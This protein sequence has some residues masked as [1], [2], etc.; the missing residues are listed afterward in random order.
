MQRAAVISLHTSPLLQ[1][2]SGDSGGMNVY[3]RELVSALAQAGV[4]CTTFTRADR[5]GLPREVVVEPGH[6]VVHIEAGPHHLPKEAL[7]DITDQFR[8]G[9]LDWFARNE[10]PDVIHGNYW[11]S[12]VVGHS[13]KH[14]LDVPFVSTFHTLARVKAAGGDPESMQRD[15]AEAQI[16]RCADAICVSCIEEEDQFRLH[17]G[18]PEARVEIIA[19]GV[20]HAFFAPGDRAGARRALGFDVDRPLLLFVGRIQPLKG[21]DVAIRALHELGDPQA[22]LVIVGGASG[23]DGDTETRRAHALVDELGLHDRVRFVE[24]QPHHILSTYYRA[25]DVV[26]APSRSESFGSG[27]TRGGGVRDPRGR[28]RCRRPA[29][30]RRR[31]SHRSTHRR[32]RSQRLRPC[33]CRDPRGRHVARL[34]ERGGGRTGAALHVEFR[35]RPTAPSLRRPHRAGTGDLSVSE[36]YDSGELAELEHRID[37]WLATLAAENERIIAVDRDTDAIRWY[38][39]MRGD[40]KEFT[41]VWLTLGQRTLRYETYVMPAPEENDAELYEHLL[42]RNDRLVGAHFSIGIEDAIFLRGEMPVGQVTHDE[43][44]RV[45]GT[46]YADVEQC[47]QSLLRIGFRSRFTA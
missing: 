41:T 2:G 11:L 18:N 19:P 29:Q 23:L 38:V 24:P 20:E 25:A 47:F 46:L 14:E 21:P 7:A 15:L 32:P 44:D 1:P 3:V 8:R 35:R 39:R 12:G 17:Y 40:D 45:L 37:G 31:R 13:L 28:Q 9:M 6:R 36:A 26:L 16:V 4:E 33:R 10:R 34:D 5:D 43:L 30:P 27:R 42:R 22:E